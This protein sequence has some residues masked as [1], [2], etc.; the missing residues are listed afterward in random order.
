MC[1]TLKGTH[2]LILSVW[3]VNKYI[4]I[5]FCL[6]KIALV[7]TVAMGKEMRNIKLLWQIDPSAMMDG[8][9]LSIWHTSVFLSTGRHMHTQPHTPSST[10]SHPLQV[11]RRRIQSVSVNLPV[12][13]VTCHE[14]QIS[15]SHSSDAS[16]RKA[17]NDTFRRKFLAMKPY[18]IPPR[19]VY[20][21]SDSQL[22][23]SEQRTSA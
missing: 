22:T 11:P 23:H 19:S 9:S 10:G 17:C 18:L 15:C 13:L 7:F 8:T 21:C 4:Y 2:S 1:V 3:T 5:M 20:D 6:L 12:L 16:A 14:N